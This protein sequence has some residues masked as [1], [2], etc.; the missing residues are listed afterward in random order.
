MKNA[1]KE[2]IFPFSPI[3]STAPRTPPR[4]SRRNTPKTGRNAQKRHPAP[5]NRKTPKTLFLSRHGIRHRKN[6]GKTAQYRAQNG[7]KSEGLTGENALKHGSC[8]KKTKYRKCSP[9]HRT[10]RKNPPHPLR[11]RSQQM[12]TPRKA[13]RRAVFAG[14]RHFPTFSSFSVTFRRFSSLFV[15]FR[16]GGF[17]GSLR[18]SLSRTRRC[19]R[20]MRAE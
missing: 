19:P 14:F 16:H 2:R 13:G 20:R 5:T 15:K 17:C 6:D 1:R 10:A 4:V 3:F 11:D 8:P 7:L 9:L 18:V 12:K